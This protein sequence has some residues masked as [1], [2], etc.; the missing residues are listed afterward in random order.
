METQKVVFIDKE[1]ESEIYKKLFATHCEVIDIS[2][3]KPEEISA[4]I[5]ERLKGTEIVPILE[6][7]AKIEKLIKQIEKEL[8][9]AKKNIDNAINKIDLKDCERWI[10]IKKG[11]EKR[12][13]RLEEIKQEL[14]EKLPNTL[15]ESKIEFEAIG[16]ETII[17]NELDGVIQKIKDTDKY[18]SENIND[19]N[20]ESLINTFKKME[21]KNI[22]N[23]NDNIP[24]IPTR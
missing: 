11:I 18:I 20:L 16:E 13:E 5:F 3:L 9:N 10:D 22:D 7:I 2:R 23:K 6:E 12:I 15:K 1:K 4:I 19:K 24:K 8:E 14:K 17:P 21:T